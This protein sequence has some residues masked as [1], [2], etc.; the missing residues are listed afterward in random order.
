[1]NSISFFFQKYV[2]ESI[3]LQHHLFSHIANIHIKH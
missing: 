3:D 1:M 2:L